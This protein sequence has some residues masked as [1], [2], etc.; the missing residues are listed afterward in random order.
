MYKDNIQ[1]QAPPSGLS[2]HWERARREH[3]FYSAKLLSA[4]VVLDGRSQDVHF[5]YVERRLLTLLF[6]QSAGLYFIAGLKLDFFGVHNSIIFKTVLFG[7][8]SRRWQNE[9]TA[10]TVVFDAPLCN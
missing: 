9:K 4:G 7:L 3:E 10:S 5:D 2:N 1:F 8:P 6:K